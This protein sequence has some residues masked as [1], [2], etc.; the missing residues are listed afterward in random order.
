MIAIARATMPTTL[1]GGKELQ[2]LPAGHFRA[3]DKRPTDAP[4]W[5]IDSAVAK[6]LIAS[7]GTRKT[8]FV[9]DYEHQTINSEK[10]GRPAPAA[11]WFRNLEWREGLGLFATD[12]RWTA[13][14]ANMIRNGEYRYLSPVFAYERPAG[15][16]TSLESASLT[17]LPALDGMATVALR[18]DSTLLYDLTIDLTEDDIDVCKTLNL[19]PVQFAREVIP[20]RRTAEEVKK[21]MALNKP[22]LD[23]RELKICELLGMTPEAFARQKDIKKR[24]E[25]VARDSRY[26]KTADAACSLTDIDRVVCAQLNL[27]EADFLRTKISGE[28]NSRTA[29]RIDSGSLTDFEQAMCAR[30]NISPEE[31]LKAKGED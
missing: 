21:T 22:G 16:I 2:L 26:A 5:F 13:A 12:V 31:F 15:R 25:E 3:R 28:S 18:K 23:K 10:N 1:T 14:A 8:D 29:A 17:N 11:G 7:A 9:I 27:S 30:M 24:A 6:A 4:S 19:D 20:R